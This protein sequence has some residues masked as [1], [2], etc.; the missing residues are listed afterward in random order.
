MDH[1]VL[2]VIGACCVGF[3]MTWG[4]G[5]ND[6]AN[7]LSTTL[8]SKAVTVRQAMLIAIVFEFAGAL[9]GSSG[10]SNTISNG[11]LHTD[12]LANTPNILAYGMMA[13]LLAGSS[14]ML[15]ASYFGLPVSITNA[16]VGSLVGFG[17]VV[18]GMHAIVWPHVRAIA[19]SWLISPFLAGVAAYLLFRSVQRT[20]LMTVN[21]LENAQR[22]LPLYFFLVGIVLAFMTVLKAIKHF[23]FAA[24]TFWESCLVVIATSF[25][26]TGIG[27]WLSRRISLEPDATGHD[28]FA[29][30]ERLFSLLM[31]FTACAMVFAHGSNDVAVAVGPIA[32]II[33]IAQS[34]DHIIH[35]GHLPFEII[36][37]GICGVL[38]GL[39]MYGRKV[40]ETVGR[41][42]TTLT[43]SRAFAATLSAAATVI[44]STS[45]GIPVS[46]TQTLVGGVLGVGLAR[47]IGAL[48]LYVVRNILLSWLITIPAASVLA[49]LFYYLLVNVFK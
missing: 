13:V 42:I 45:I 25:F 18:L 47:G 11:I 17:A 34:N 1:S 20:I 19:I 12:V 33:N 24:L 39:F 28:R 8:G 23:E 6:L 14:W 41:G 3:I 9:L 40:I 5:A 15:L 27:L 16:I 37:L 38:T 31:A 4:V 35:G 2:F 10:V 44:V 29:A 46:A 48:N 36:L 21:P 43:P 26:I 49:I 30:V 32:A 7:I 22:Y